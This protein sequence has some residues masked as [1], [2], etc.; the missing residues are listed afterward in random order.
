[1]RPLAT[2][3]GAPLVGID[4]KVSG[5][6]ADAMTWVSCDMESEAGTRA[7]RR[8]APLVGIDG[9]VSGL[10]ADAMTWVSCDIGPEAPTGAAGILSSSDKS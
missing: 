4:G 10:G 7:T 6:G 3:R 9:K 2:R 1:M 5:L 8:G